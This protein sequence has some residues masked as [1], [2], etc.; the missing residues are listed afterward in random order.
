[1][2]EE[3]AGPLLALSLGR[4]FILPAPSISVKPHL[5]GRPRWMIQFV[6]TVSIFAFLAVSSSLAII[7][8]A[9]KLRLDELCLGICRILAVPTEKRLSGNQ[10]GYALGA[11]ACQ[12]R[13]RPETSYLN[14]IC[15]L[16][17]ASGLLWTSR[18][19]SCYR[20]GHQETLHEIH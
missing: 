19:A 3:I 1:M 6:F 18:V 12:D 4:Q 5:F 11:G 15:G 2:G 13:F 10:A 14:C 7:L 20:Q 8:Y 16:R 17:P 9:P